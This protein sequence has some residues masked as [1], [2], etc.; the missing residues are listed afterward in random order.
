VATLLAQFTSPVCAGNHTTVGTPVRQT[1]LDQRKQERSLAWTVVARLDTAIPD[2]RQPQLP[3]LPVHRAFV[4][5]DVISTV[6]SL[7]H[8]KSLHRDIRI[9][10]LP[11]GRT[12]QVVVRDRRCSQEMVVSG[13]S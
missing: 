10:Q 1:N 9:S 8:D 7:P 5:T 12:Q 11:V 13:L 6:P 2:N 4:T 3:R